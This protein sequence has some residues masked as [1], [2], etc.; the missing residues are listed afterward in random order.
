MSTT[1]T[2]DRIANKSYQ[3][4]ED[5]DSLSCTSAIYLNEDGTLSIGRTDGPKPDR[6]YA[7]WKYSDEEGEIV[8]NI[9]RFFGADTNTPFSV[10]RI[11]RGHIEKTSKNL[12]DLAIFSGGMYQEPADF[13]PQSEVGWF[14]MIIATDDLP[15]DDFD[16]STSQ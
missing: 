6:V 15:T 4:E 7:T 1:V 10:K 11:L 9:E 13:S 5:E 8:L 3:L 12:S 16:I 14:S 2:N